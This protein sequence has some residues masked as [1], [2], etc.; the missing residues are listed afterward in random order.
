MRKPGSSPE[1]LAPEW[2]AG[3]RIGS[4]KGSRRTGWTADRIELRG[5]QTSV[6]DSLN[7]TLVV[8]RKIEYVFLELELNILDAAHK[9]IHGYPGGCESL[10]PRLGMA[11]QV[12]RNK[13]NPNTESHH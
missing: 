4:R 6:F 11:P 9:V 7:Q 1:C 10:A 8:L 5:N 2:G 13:A 12:L 3:K